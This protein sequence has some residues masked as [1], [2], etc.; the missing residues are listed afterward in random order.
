L[1]R[2]IDEFL[3]RGEPVYKSRDWHPPTTKHFADYGGVWP[4]HC[5][6]NTKARSFI[7]PCA[8]IHASP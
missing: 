5:V 7:Q 1:N 8:T 6:Q 4:V 2:A 3:A